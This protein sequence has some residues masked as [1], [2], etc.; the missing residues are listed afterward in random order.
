MQNLPGFIEQQVLV[1]A[2]QILKFVTLCARIEDQENKQPELP[3]RLAVCLGTKYNLS[4]A[5][6]I[7][8]LA[9]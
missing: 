7:T 8:E 9:E 2:I 1:F 3:P 6:N 4:N 5:Q